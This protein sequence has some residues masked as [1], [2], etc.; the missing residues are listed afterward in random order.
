MTEIIAYAVS[1]DIED[2]KEYIFSRADFDSLMAYET[3]ESALY[4]SSH[5]KVYKL[6]IQVEEIE[7][8]ESA[9]S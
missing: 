6:T 8:N 1:E 4:Y 2:L 5:C 9:A 7:K 3:L